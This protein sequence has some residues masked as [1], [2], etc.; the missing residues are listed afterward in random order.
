[1]MAL[2][3]GSPS[4]W[5]PWKVSQVIYQFSVSVSIKRKQRGCHQ[6]LFSL[7]F[8]VHFSTQLLFTLLTPPFSFMLIFAM[9]IHAHEQTT[10]TRF[11]WYDRT[12]NNSSTGLLTFRNSPV[13]IPLRPDPVLEPHLPPPNAPTTQ[14]SGLPGH[15]ARVGVHL[16][17]E[18]SW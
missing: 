4:F 13:V 14:S 6:T 2:S 12:L 10:R 8:F 1:M 3:F 7:V 16:L 15:G 18:H 5:I 9:F 17:P 11:D